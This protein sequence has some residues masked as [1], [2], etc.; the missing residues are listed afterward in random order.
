MGEFVTGDLI[1]VFEDGMEGGEMKALEGLESIAFIFGRHEGRKD[2]LRQIHLA[3]EVHEK[4]GE[5]ALGERF[6]EQVNRRRLAHAS[7]SLHNHNRF[8]HR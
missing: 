3:V 6:P 2:T 5:A 8:T 1:G 7:L 4:N